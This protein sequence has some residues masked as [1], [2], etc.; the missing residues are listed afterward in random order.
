MISIPIMSHVNHRHDQHSDYQQTQGR[1][2]K[3]LMIASP[4][5]FLS[6]PRSNK[7]NQESII[8]GNEQDRDYCLPTTT[9]TPLRSQAPSFDDT[10]SFS[11]L[12]RQPKRQNQDTTTTRASTTPASD[13]L[14]GSDM[15]MCIEKQS[16]R[17]RASLLLCRS[18]NTATTKDNSNNNDNTTMTDTD[19]NNHVEN[20]STALL[21]NSSG[22]PSNFSQFVRRFQCE[23]TAE[24]EEEEDVAE[25]AITLTRATKRTTQEQRHHQQVEKLVITP[26]SPNEVTMTTIHTTPPPQPDYNNNKN[27]VQEPHPIDPI[28]F[29]T[30]RERKLAFNLELMSQ[31]VQRHRAAHRIKNKKKNSTSIMIP[32]RMISTLDRIV[33]DEISTMTMDDALQSPMSQKRD[34]CRDMNSQSVSW[35]DATTTTVA[36]STSSTSSPRPS[37][38]DPENSQG[39]FF[40]II[41]PFP[42]IVED[43][44]ATTKEIQLLSQ[45]IKSTLGA[46]AMTTGGFC[47]GGGNENLMMM[48]QHMQAP[49]LPY[50]NTTSA[51]VVTPP[52]RKQQEQNMLTPLKR[53]KTNQIDPTTA[54][55]SS[56]SSSLRRTTTIRRIPTSNK[57]TEAPGFFVCPNDNNESL[58]VL[59]KRN[60]NNHNKRVQFSDPIVTAVRVRPF[61]KANEV[62]NLFFDPGELD[63]LSKDRANRIPDEQFECIA[64]STGDVSVRFPRVHYAK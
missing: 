12:T 63:I 2:R 11:Q 51:A 16:F 17:S 62:P 36:T 28:C 39:C 60:N 33:D 46:T 6:D 54:L 25:E 20:H 48:I 35:H 38:P 58:A 15:L 23:P 24:E 10:T 57:T 45:Q 42:T 21:H 31:Q 64:R 40:G 3:S 43:L 26:L 44:T 22:G 1:G 5:L 52:R 19:N 8:Y 34:I 9:T 32:V 53:E 29:T 7:S 55:S 61:T 30:D 13:E 59:V 27:N 41:E 56:S 37:S 49:C 14:D 47:L 18:Y 50:V 4:H